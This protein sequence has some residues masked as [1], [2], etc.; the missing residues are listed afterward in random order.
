MRRRHRGRGLHRAPGG[1]L[2]GLAAARSA[3]RRRRAR[4]R[5]LRPFGAQWRLGLGRPRRQRGALRAAARRRRRAP[6][7]ARHRRAV[8]GIGSV[9]A[10]EGIECG[11]LHGGSLLVAT[12]AP[13]VAR[14]HQAVERRRAFGIGEDD[15]RLLEPPE[16]YQRVRVRGARAASFTPHCAVSTRAAR[17]RARTR[18]RAAGRRDLRGDDSREHRAG[19]RALR[20][21]QP[22]RRLRAACDRGLHGAAGGR[23]P[24]VH[25]ALLAD[26]RHRAAASGGLEGDRLGGP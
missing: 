23:A 9:V 1:L 12:S 8:A 7:R 15:L 21:G 16:I 26:D 22:P 19:P 6:R 14:L 2:P 4:D 10:E 18:V 13:Q 17:A 20:D 25:A 11:W 3:H 24:A 5:R